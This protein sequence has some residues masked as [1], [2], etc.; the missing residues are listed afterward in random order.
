MVLDGCAQGLW[1]SAGLAGNRTRPEAWVPT[2]PPFGLKDGERR[3]RPSEGP[4][5]TQSS[6]RAPSVRGFSPPG[7]LSSSSSS[8]PLAKSFPAGASQP[9][10][11]L[12][13]VWLRLGQGQPVLGQEG[14]SH[15]AGSGGRGKAAG[16]CARR[17]PGADPRC[18]P[19]LTAACRGESAL[20]LGRVGSPHLSG[21]LASGA[22]LATPAQLGP[23]LGP[24]RPLCLAGC[25]RGRFEQFSTSCVQGG[26]A[27]TDTRA[28]QRGSM[29]GLSFLQGTHAHLN[30][31]T[32]VPGGSKTEGPPL[33]QVAAEVLWCFTRCSTPLGCVRGKPTS[34]ATGPRGPTD[35]TLAT[36]PS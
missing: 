1:V 4:G 35:P 11:S 12:P 25:N 22:A 8:S 33:G 27:H 10:L 32:H 31:S 26:D 36:P 34:L 17:W 5:R 30:F 15:A 19:P 28:N 24:Q 20:L 21:C 7:T 3:G 9:L 16:G 2:A 6:A 29:C 13:R 14:S 23:V 18:A